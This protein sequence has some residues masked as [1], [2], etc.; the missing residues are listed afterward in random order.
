MP[1][2]RAILMAINFQIGLSI[3][4]GRIPPTAVLMTVVILHGRPI[5]TTTGA[6]M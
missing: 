5:L 6:W 2:I 4:Q 3:Q 1:A